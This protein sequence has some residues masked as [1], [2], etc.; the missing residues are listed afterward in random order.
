MNKI[1][2]HCWLV[3]FFVSLLFIEFS[4]VY[5]T[6]NYAKPTISQ[7]TYEIHL[8]QEIL[9]KLL[10]FADK[11]H[12]IIPSSQITLNNRELGKTSAVGEVHIVS[13][14]TIKFVTKEK[15]RFSPDS[16][17][18][19]VTFSKIDDCDDNNAAIIVRTG[20]WINFFGVAFCPG[21]VF[22]IPG[23]SQCI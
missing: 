20:R 12:P 4:K 14:K 22:N 23:E 19:S 13:D 2:R 9:K 18:T 3:V 8:S 15:L 6:S 7:N 21:Q 16:D 5:A 10:E 17:G 11:R 1:T